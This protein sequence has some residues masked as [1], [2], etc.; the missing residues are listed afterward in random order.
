MKAKRNNLIFFILYLLLFNI[1]QCPY[2]NSIKS[3]EASKKKYQKKLSRNNGFIEYSKGNT[4]NTNTN[5]NKK[6]RM[7]DD[8]DLTLS[9]YNRCDHGHTPDDISDCTKYDTRDSSCCIFK[10]GQDTGC[11]LIGFKYLGSKSVGDMTVN[12]FT[13]YLKSLNFLIIAMIFFLL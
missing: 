5:T 13:I 3:Q 1:Y 7:D 6:R 8:E 10:Y 4:K 11:V 2:I 12:C 9:V